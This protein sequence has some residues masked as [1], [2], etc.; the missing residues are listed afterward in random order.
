[1]SQLQEEIGKKMQEQLT[2]LQQRLE[3]V[4]LAAERRSNEGQPT[5]VMGEVEATT[6]HFSQMVERGAE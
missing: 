1:M 3:I 5:G 4:S 2:E 6:S